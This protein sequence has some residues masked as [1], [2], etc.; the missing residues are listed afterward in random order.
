MYYSNAFLFVPTT[1]SCSNLFLAGILILI[2]NYG[3]LIC[4]AEKTAS[5]YND[6]GESW[7]LEGDYHAAIS[8]FLKATTIN[9]NY[10]EAWN[11]LGLVYS[12]EEQNIEA[13]TAFRRAVLINPRYTEAW[14]NLGDVYTKMGRYDDAREAYQKATSINTNTQQNQFPPSDHQWNEPPMGNNQ[15]GMYN[16]PPGT[17]P[18]PP[19]SPWNKNPGQIPGR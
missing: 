3:V 14:N 10:A 7:Y 17:A 12:Q 8:A 19:Q 1:K 2:L 4:G 5:D 13:V 9:S 15:P 18:M 16:P 6:L 11:N